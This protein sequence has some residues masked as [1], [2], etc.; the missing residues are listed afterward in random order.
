MSDKSKQVRKP[1]KYRAGTRIDFE[2]SMTVYGLD[3]AGRKRILGYYDPVLGVFQGGGE[4]KE[5][6]NVSH[7]PTVMSMHKETLET[8]N[9]LGVQTWEM[10]EH[11]NN[12][13]YRI[14]MSKARSV[15]IYYRTSMGQRFG[16]PIQY[17]D[18]I[19]STGR[20]LKQGLESP[21]MTMF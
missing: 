6:L 13:C 1:P 9:K 4:S 11:M 17:I 2:R 12:I 15:G 7:E 3:R 14:S 16:V 8:L 21:Q 19:D 18:E 20:V 10:I 5:I